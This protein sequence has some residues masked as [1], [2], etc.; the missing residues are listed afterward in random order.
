MQVKIV[1]VGEIMAGEPL[2]IFTALLV[3]I[4]KGAGRCVNMSTIFMFGVAVFLMLIGYLVSDLI[5]MTDPS[6]YLRG[7]ARVA[8]YGFDM[9]ALAVVVSHGS[10]HLWWFAFG[11]GAGILINLLLVPT[12]LNV[13]SWKLGYGQGIGL[14]VALLAGFLGRVAGPLVIA[15]VGIVS[16][17]LDFRSFS[18]IFIGVSGIM[19][20]Q[21]RR[22]GTQRRYLIRALLFVVA[23][24]VA[25]TVIVV[26]LMLSDEEF[27]LRRK[28]SNLGRYIGLVVA[29]RAVIDSPFIG[30]GSWAADKHYVVILNQELANAAAG[31]NI[32]VTKAESIMPHSQ[33]IQ[34]WLEGGLLGVLF[35]LI[36]GWHLLLALHWLTFSHMPDRMTPLYLVFVG[37]GLWNLAASPFLG[38]QHR[39]NIACAVVVLALLVKE[40]G[41]AINTNMQARKHMANKY[42]A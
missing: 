16:N 3:L 30:Y 2:L 13:T 42:S 28:E 11:L 8:L 36:Y 37:T 39:I 14:L 38:G 21:S 41:L 9:L 4:L 22:Q 15:G 17:F 25:S 29:A 12:P 35:F 27:N 6:Q 1:L 24:T 20:A 31:T 26:T 34:A 7:W 33:L 10:R 40:R 5:A 23:L 19:M 18:G 32:P